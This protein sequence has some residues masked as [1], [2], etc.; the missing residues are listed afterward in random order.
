MYSHNHIG[1]KR[2]LFDDSV[3]VDSL[4]VES[5]ISDWAAVSS[6]SGRTVET[7]FWVTP[8]SKSSRIQVIWY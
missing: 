2:I 6:I 4:R 7:V 1:Q 5:L 3:D 8:G